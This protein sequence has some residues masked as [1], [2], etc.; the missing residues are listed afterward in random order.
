MSNNND[1]TRLAILYY[2]S[3]GYLPRQIADT[4]HLDERYVV[5]VMIADEFKRVFKK[6]ESK[7]T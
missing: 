2:K 6:K 3:L 7:K 1:E 4:L 5:N